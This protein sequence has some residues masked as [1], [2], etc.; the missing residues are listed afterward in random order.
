MLKKLRK[1]DFVNKSLRTVLKTFGKTSRSLYDKSI[2][3]WRTSGIIPCTFD[4]YHFKMFNN[5]DDGLV[6]YFYYNKKYHEEHDLKLFLSMA[7]EAQTILDI[8]ANTGLYSI[9]TAKA[10]P[11]SVIHAIEPYLTN[12]NRLNKNLELNGA[13]NVVTYPIALGEQEGQLSFSVPKADIVTDV[14]SFDISFSK[15]FHPELEW[16]KTNVDVTTLDAFT[17]KLATKIDLIKCDVEG[18][19]ISVFKGALKT[20]EQHKPVVLFEC[21]LDEERKQFFDMILSNY[22]YT[23]YLVLTEGLVQVKSFN[24]NITGLNYLIA[25]YE[26]KEQFLSYNEVEKNVKSF[27]SKN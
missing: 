25:P 4:S 9:L 11:S 6:E 3:K 21:F 22:G 23:L 2:A 15:K 17:S 18:F 19:E 26:S 20:L 12:Y 24:K 13:G 14:S 7:K 10:N 27:F 16:V 1:N 8:G 5:C